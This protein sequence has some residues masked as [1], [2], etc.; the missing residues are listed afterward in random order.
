MRVSVTFL[1][2][3]PSTSYK[4]SEK[5]SEQLLNSFVADGRVDKRTD[6]Q[7]QVLK[8]FPISANFQKF[9]LGVIGGFSKAA[10]S[11]LVSLQRKHYFFPKLHF[12][13]PCFVLLNSDKYVIL[14]TVMFGISGFCIIGFSELRSLWMAT[15]N[16][17][18]KSWQIH[19]LMFDV[20]IV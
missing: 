2:L 18:G 14:V 11:Q 8:N 12:L 7:S 3:Q 9:I 19:L 1:A 16:A 15:H 20:A 5:T 4:R 13:Y 17:L 10:S 6:E